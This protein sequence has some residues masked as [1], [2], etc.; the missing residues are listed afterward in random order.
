MNNQNAIRMTALAA[1]I[2]AACTLA[3]AQDI[4]LYEGYVLP[5][6]VVLEPMAQE[7]LSLDVDL[8]ISGPGEFFLRK[9]FKA[10]TLSEFDPR[11]L[12]GGALPDGI[13]TYEIQIAGPASGPKTRKD[14][15]A[16]SFEG[17]RLAGGYGSFSIRGGELVHA[18]ETEKAFEPKAAETLASTSSDSEKDATRDQVILDDLIVDGSAC[19]GQDCVNGES[20]GFDTIRLKENNLRIKFQDTSNSSAFPTTDWQLTANESTNGGLSKFSIDDIDGGRTPFTI[21]ANAPSNSLYVDD[22][23]RMGF[24][25][26]T[27]VVEMHSV[28]GDTPTLRI[29]QDGSSG[30]AQ[31]TWDIAGNESNFFVRDVTNGSQLP[32]RIQ[33]GAASNTIYIAN[34]EQVGYGTAS[35]TAPID[36]NASA[37]IGPGNSAIRASNASGAVGLQLDPNND[38]TFWFITANSD[39]DTFRIN[40]NG[41]T[42]EVEFE[43][44]QSTGNLTIPGSI[45]TGGGTCGGGC[46]LVFTDQYSLPTI[47]EHSEAMWDKGYL[48]SVGPTLENQPINLSEKTGRML[49]ELETAHIYI[50]QLHKRLAK[51]EAKLE[52]VEFD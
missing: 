9:N 21:E 8:V 10:G 40:R 20:F 16:E 12:A 18:D 17:P 30:F 46:D 19:I 25:T 5:D 34:D 36:V 43:I 49:N 50:E 45:I 2:A 44:E 37:N 6:A 41:G 26:S 51:L 29:Q 3:N 47:E 31:Q 1:A 14:S 23:G 11:S 15:D 7:S 22:G 38:G 27:P 33:P 42:G 24:G 4:T 28:N 13:Y 39:N 35:P 48:P 52:G 32:F